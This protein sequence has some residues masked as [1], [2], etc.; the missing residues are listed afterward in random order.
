M[1]N[2]RIEFECEEHEVDAVVADGRWQ[3]QE[4]TPVVIQTK[5]VGVITV[6]DPDT[7]LPVELEIRKLEGGPMVALDG[8][9][10]EQSEELPF[11]PYD[12]GMVLDIPTDE[13]PSTIAVHVVDTKEV[14][15]YQDVLVTALKVGDKVDLGSCP[16][17][18][19]HPSAEFELAEVG[20]IRR[21]T[22]DCVVVSYDGIDEV[23]YPPGTVLKVLQ[24]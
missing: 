5:C 12:E 3:L 11:S 8:C 23:G 1:P 4:V 18:Y 14:P 19:K 20:E 7:N 13:E 22:P 16:F 6:K 9:F 24:E 15:V 10:L 2:Y 21:E 17:L